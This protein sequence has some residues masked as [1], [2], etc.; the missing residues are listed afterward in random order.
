M[1]GMDRATGKRLEGRAHLAQRLADILSTPVGT[2]IMRL[3]YGS[4]LFELVDQPMK[5]LGRLR[6]FAATAVAITRWEPLFRLTRVDLTFAA[7]GKA[8]LD[9]EGLDLEVPAPS[10]L[11]RLSI[12]LTLPLQPAT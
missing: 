2:R 8:V 3:D 6:L 1:I 12:P 11:A 7:D 10:A 5:A 9:L 4:M